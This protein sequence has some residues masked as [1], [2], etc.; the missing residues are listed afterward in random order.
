MVPNEI[1]QCIQK[2]QTFLDGR[3]YKR[4]EIF[5]AAPNYFDLNYEERRDLLKAPS[6]DYL[7]KSIVME[8][9]AYDE[10]FADPKVYPK[11]ICVVIQYITKLKG[12][13]LN[14]YFKSIQNS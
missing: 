13:N 4:Y 10:R 3:G 8:N 5:Q 9:T 2:L 11:Y 1:A 12:E 14:K 7:C 6:T